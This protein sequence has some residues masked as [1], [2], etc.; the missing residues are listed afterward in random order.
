[1]GQEDVQQKEE[2]GFMDH[3]EELRRRLF[4]ALIGILTGG[5]TLFVMKDWVFERLIFAPRNPDFITFRALGAP[6]VNSPEP[7]T[8]CASQKSTTS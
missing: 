2:M 1:M 6:W 5:I 8:A 7:E 4:F 3:L